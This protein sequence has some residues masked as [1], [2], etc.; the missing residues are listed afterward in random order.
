MSDE[1]N[2]VPKD[3]FCKGS[4]SQ[5]KYMVLPDTGKIIFNGPKVVLMTALTAE[6]N[7]IPVHSSEALES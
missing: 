6:K 7:K 5:E 4:H 1:L 3:P 2:S